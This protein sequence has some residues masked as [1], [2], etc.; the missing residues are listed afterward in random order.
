LDVAI[1]LILFTLLGFVLGYAVPHWSAWL[2]LLVPVVF[3]AATIIAEGF[4]L[5]TILVLV[6][7]LAL[8]AAAIIAG[9]F[10]DAKLAQRR[11]ETA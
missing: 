10:L 6:I 8:M 1:G 3:A 11:E 5:S 2:A 7:A 4:A 9:R